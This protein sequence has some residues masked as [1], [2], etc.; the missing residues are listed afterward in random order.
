[1]NPRSSK[2]R[3]YIFFT[4]RDVANNLLQLKG[5]VEGLVLHLRDAAM[6]LGLFFLQNKTYL[7]F[8]LKQIICDFSP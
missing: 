2:V 6:Y 3:Q 8:E 5:E 7:T 1:M 4:K